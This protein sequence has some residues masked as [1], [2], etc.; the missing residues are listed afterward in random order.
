MFN[1]LYKFSRLFSNNFLSVSEFFLPSSKKVS[2]LLCA[3]YMIFFP[4]KQEVGWK[5]CK[6]GGEGERRKRIHSIEE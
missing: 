5:D 6:E 2:V 1:F 4:W 3:D